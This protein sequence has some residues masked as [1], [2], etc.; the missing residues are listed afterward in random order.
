MNCLSIVNLIIARHKTSKYFSSYFSS[1]Q[2]TNCV[3]VLFLQ[4]S[5]FICFKFNFCQSPLQ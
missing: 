2:L 4:V 1:L 3:F 5:Y